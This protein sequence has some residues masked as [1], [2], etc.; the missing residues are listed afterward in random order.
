[1]KIWLPDNQTATVEW[2]VTDQKQLLGIN[3]VRD[4]WAAREIASTQLG[5]GACDP[6]RDDKPSRFRV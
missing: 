1:M 2:Y 5:F 6:A 4:E 3:E